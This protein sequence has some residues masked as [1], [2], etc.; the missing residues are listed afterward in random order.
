MQTIMVD[1]G[2]GPIPVT[3]FTLFML[4]KKVIIKAR[5][6]AINETSAIFSLEDTV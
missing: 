4:L 2:S 6:A 5:K 3:V 1:L